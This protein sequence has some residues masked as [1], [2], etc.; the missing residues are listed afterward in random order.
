M[1]ARTALRLS[2]AADLP[3]VAIGALTA[4]A[5]AT[6]EVPPMRTALACLALCAMYAAGGWLDDA[7]DRDLDRE[8]RPARPIPS[9][10]AA[11]GLVFDGGFALL[12]FGVLLLVSTAIGVHA[13]WRPILAIV[14]LASLVVFRA[15]AS[16]HPAAPALLGACRVGVYAIPMLLVAPRLPL[17]PEVLFAAGLAAVYMSG[18]AAAARQDQFEELGA[19]WPLALLGLP[20]L[21][22]RPDDTPTLA[23]YAA[24]AAWLVRGLSLVRAGDHDRAR[25]HLLAGAALLDALMLVAFGKHELAIAAAA[26]CVLAR[27]IDRALA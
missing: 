11:A 26:A 17:R 13:G 8:R 12:L 20:F 3:V 5:L 9:G 2:R 19:M 24:L 23:A 14:A 22:I 6:P 16:E 15:A 4:A 18:A 25:A 27:G 10:E 7:F 1:K 21:V